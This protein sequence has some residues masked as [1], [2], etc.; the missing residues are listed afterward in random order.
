MSI[1]RVIFKKKVSRSIGG[2]IVLVVFLSLIGILMILPFVYTISTSLKPANELW[3]FPPRFFVIKPTLKNFSDLFSLMSDSWIPFSRYIF[4]TVFIT[5][6][7]TLLHIVLASMCAYPLSR[8]KFPGSGFIFTVIQTTLMFSSAVTAIPSFII[9]SKLHLIDTYTAVIFPAVGAPLGLFIMKQFMDQTVNL[10]VLES[11]DID[12]VDNAYDF[13]GSVALG[14][15][16]L[17]L[18]IQRTAQDPFLRAEPGSGGGHSPR[19]SRRSHYRAYDAG[20][21]CGLY[22]FAVQCYGNNVD[23]RHERLR[24]FCEIFEIP[25]CVTDYR[26]DAFSGNGGRI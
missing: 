16:K 14:A 23:V 5:A 11:A 19:G 2:D 13:H 24:C 26:A 3:L 21:A 12:C 20:S 10:S 8:Y 4:N 9:M 6:A 22:C 17:V 7:G 1:L 25:F 18:H 15:R